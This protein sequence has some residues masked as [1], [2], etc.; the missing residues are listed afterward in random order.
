MA[1]P[2]DPPVVWPGKVSDDGLRSCF[3]QSPVGALYANANVWASSFNG[4]K[5]AVTRELMV[6]G[7]TRDETL[8]S[9]EDGEGGGPESSGMRRSQVSITSHIRRRRLW[10][11]SSWSVRMARWV[12]CR[13]RWSG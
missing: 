7:P 10:W 12:H 1:V 5:K 8:A 13:R 6:D 9:I 11:S 4:L 2:P 3:A